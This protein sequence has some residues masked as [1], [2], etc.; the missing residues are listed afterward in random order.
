M[1]KNERLRELYK[2]YGLSQEDT[3]KS[4]Q[5]WTIITRQGIDAIQASAGIDIEYISEVIERDF[6]VVKAKATMGDA[7]VE[8]YG[9][10]DRGP[11]GNCRQNYP[12]AMAEKRAMSRAV[13]K[14]S[15]FYALGAYGEDEGDFKKAEKQSITTRAISKA[16]DM[17]L[18]GEKTAEEMI[19][20]LEESYEVGES[21]KFN[22]KQLK[23]Q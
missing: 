13:L 4:P 18:R 23:K 16:N 5:G 17:V 21:I 22:L 3:F 11:K 9:E 19:E 6:V 10:A 20:I 15:G 8:T 12:V 2:K 14:L 1:T 7:K